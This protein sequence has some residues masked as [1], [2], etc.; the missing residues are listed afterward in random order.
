MDV[1][2]DYPREGWDANSDYVMYELAIEFLR[3]TSRRGLHGEW[4]E[5]PPSYRHE[6]HEIVINF[7][8]QVRVFFTDELKSIIDVQVAVPFPD[9][10]IDYRILKTWKSFDDRGLIFNG[11]DTNGW[12]FE[13]DTDDHEKIPLNTQ[14]DELTGN[15]TEKHGEP[16]RPHEPEDVWAWEERWIKNREP[17]DIKPEWLEKLYANSKRGMKYADPNSQFK[18][19]MKR[20]W[21]KKGQN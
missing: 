10:G 15:V 14:S 13:N 7:P 2:F 19:I 4:I 9:K 21:L 1:S 8:G 20:D 5:D 3:E 16:G 17:K 11:P 12:F 6:K 18:R